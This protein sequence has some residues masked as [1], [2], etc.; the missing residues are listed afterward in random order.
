MKA[1][2]T[3]ATPTLGCRPRSRQ[4]QPLARGAGN[5]GA[6]EEGYG[7]FG[8]N[9]LVTHTLKRS[10]A[11]ETTDASMVCQTPGSANA[12]RASC[13]STSTSTGFTRW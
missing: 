13:A 8:G 5:P 3:V 4:E 7:D 12:R 2:V 9:A 1:T 10:C 11:A 6:V